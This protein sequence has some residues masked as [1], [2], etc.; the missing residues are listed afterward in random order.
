MTNPKKLEL[1]N[2]LQL[3]DNVL[4]AEEQAIHSKD[5]KT[6]EEVTLQKDQTLEI[7]VQ[8]KEAL[9]QDGIDISDLSEE[10]D[11]II[12]RQE[13][14]TELFRGLHIQGTNSKA[15]SNPNQNTLQNRLRK[16][17]RE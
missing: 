1:I 8:I 6:I 17:Y 15:K 11:R 7:L 2:A 5:M 13:K 14:N 9:D 3:H 16:A 4:H 12:S 10:I